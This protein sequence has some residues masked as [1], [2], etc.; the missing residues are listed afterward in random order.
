[1]NANFE[2]SVLHTSYKNIIKASTLFGLLTI[3]FYLK[4][5]QHLQYRFADYGNVNHNNREDARM[6]N[7]DKLI[8]CTKSNEQFTTKDVKMASP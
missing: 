6:K 4:A 2:L 8:L 3:S 5:E 7:L 1:M